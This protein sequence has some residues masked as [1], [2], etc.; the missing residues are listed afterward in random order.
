VA[1]SPRDLAHATILIM[2]RP[3]YER[4]PALAQEAA[5][6]CMTAGNNSISSSDIRRLVREGKSVRYLVP[7]PVERFIAEHALYVE[8]S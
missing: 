1:A 3:G 6:I 7:D 8:T 5:L 4:F 2:A